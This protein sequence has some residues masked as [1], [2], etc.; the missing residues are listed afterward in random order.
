MGSRHRRASSYDLSTRELL[1]EVEERNVILKGELRREK[2]TTQTQQW[3]IQSLQD[4]YTRLKSQ[5]ES[6]RVREYENS[7]ENKNLKYKLRQKEAMLDDLDQRYHSLRRNNGDRQR[8]WNVE[9]L[10]TKLMES[11]DARAIAEIRNKN[12]DAAV[13]YL[14]AQLE[15]FG[16]RADLR[17]YGY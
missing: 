1:R 8:H 16:F 3:E 10:Q 2:Y 6:L 5:Y 7:R 9:R 13:N 17:C 12:K 15:R 4:K 11:E 14:R